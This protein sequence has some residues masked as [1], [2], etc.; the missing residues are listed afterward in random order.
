MAAEGS[1]VEV[2]MPLFQ[3]ADLHRVWVTL[4]AYE[5]NLAGLRKG[6]RV[7]FT[8]EAFPGREFLGTVS[9]VAPVVD[10]MSRTVEVRVNAANPGLLL[11]PQML[12]RAV[13]NAAKPA[14]G[15]SASLVVPAT[16]PL[17]TGE[18]ALVYVEVSS[19][20][21]GF[22][23]EGRDVVLGPRV[24]E[25][26]VVLSGLAEGEQVVVNGAFRIDSEL[27]IRARPSMMSA[28]RQ[29]ETP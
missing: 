11:K 15:G 12:A 14:G 13:V 20:S 25:F 10:P 17:L 27:Q 23:Y 6:Q 9:F 2:G 7:T 19:D 26:Y 16:A 18:R 22:G 3:I 28:G 1:Y 5:S 29:Q 24:G 21:A 8:V 4:Q